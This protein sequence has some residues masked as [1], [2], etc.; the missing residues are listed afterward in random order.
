MAVVVFVLPQPVRFLVPLLL[1]IA[2]H[3]LLTWLV[4]QTAGKALLG[5][6][7]RR[8]GHEPTFLW[9][10]GRSSAG[11]FILDMLGIGLLTAFFDARRR[12]LHDFV[13]G[14]KVIFEGDKSLRLKRLLNR[15]ENYAKRQETALKDKK[16]T[17]TALVA[18][19][20][21]LAAMALRLQRLID[22]LAAGAV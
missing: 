1:L 3:T 12:C 4:Q 15:L 18:F 9:A 13:F 17:I 20:S 14:S 7:V 21:L 2:Y 10:L 22:Y 19:W 16:K 8:I 6:R 11:Y 5:L